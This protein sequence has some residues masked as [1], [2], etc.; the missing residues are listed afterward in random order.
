[1][2][3][4]DP[5]IDVVIIVPPSERISPEV[6][7]SLPPTTRICDW[8]T[9]VLDLIESEKPEIVAFF[10]INHDFLEPETLKYG[11]EKRF[12]QQGVKVEIINN[13]DDFNRISGREIKPPDPELHPR[14]P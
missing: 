12:G 11:M 4:S 6:L 1:M 5:K 14:L 3:Y 7:A 2:E 10:D 8:D 9:N 13:V